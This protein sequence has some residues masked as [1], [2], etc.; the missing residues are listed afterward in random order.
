MNPLPN[1]PRGVI[2]TTLRQA[3]DPI[4]WALRWRRE[5]GDPMTFPPYQGKPLLVVGSP[6]AIRTLLSAPADSVEPLFV[7]RLAAV[8]GEQ[9]LL[10]LSGARHGAMRKL[11]MPPFHGQRMRVYGQTI[12]DLTLELT[13]GFTTGSHFVA[14]ELMHAISLQTIIRLVFGVAG[15]QRIARTE[16]L[17]GRYR[18]AI[19][20][21]VLPMLIPFLRRNFWGLGPWANLQRATAA[22]RALIDEE[23]A[24]RRADSAERT[25][26]LSLLLSA[27]QEDGSGLDDRQIFEQLLTLLFAGH[28][29]TAMTL[30]WALY[31]LQEEPEALAQLLAELDALGPNPK[32]EA[33]AKAPFLEAVCHETLRLYPAASAAG[34]QLLQPTEIAGCALPSGSGAVVNILWAHYNPQIFA[35]PERFLPSR[36][37]ERTYSPF[38][39]LPFGGGNRRC[40]GAA[41]ALYEMK[42]VLGTLLSRFAFERISKKPVR[43]RQFVGLEPGGPVR[44][45]VKVRGS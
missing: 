12:R 24:A 43:V 37:I 3:R 16:H 9:S 23:I 19:A 32:P 44:M 14:Q 15:A 41:F 22:L 18:S 1:G 29:T 45:R 27:R 33:L 20:R 40:I 10:V 36:F 13:R 5:Y 31:R 39:F 30:V 11:L 6:S 2:L 34:R 28:S 42:I 25:D 35:E 17:I 7:E 8:L 4:G 38:E 26:I 21:S